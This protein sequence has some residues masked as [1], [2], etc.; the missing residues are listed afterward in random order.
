MGCFR[1]NPRNALL[2][3]G[4]SADMGVW[5]LLKEENQSYKCEH[6]A[7]SSILRNDTIRNQ[8][9]YV[10]YDLIYFQTLLFLNDPVHGDE[11]HQHDDRNIIG[12]KGNDRQKLQS[13]KSSSWNTI[14]IG[15]RTDHSVLALMHSKKGDA[16]Y[17]RFPELCRNITWT[18][19]GIRSRS[20]AVTGVWKSGVRFWLFSIPFQRWSWNWLFRDK[21]N[22]TC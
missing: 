3:T 11:I 20:S 10:K 9:Y 7:F 13:W 1:T 14:W 4:R 18:L 16:G 12:Y 19:I 5:I 8:I 2:K 21:I 15:S 17:N 6:K 22:C